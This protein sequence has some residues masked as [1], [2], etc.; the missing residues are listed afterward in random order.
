MIR[1]GHAGW[2]AGAAEATLGN[3]RRT[4]DGG[5][6]ARLTR[7]H[8]RSI[9][10]SLFEGDP[11]A[12]YPRVAVPVLLAPARAEGDPAVADALASLPDARVSYYPGA[13]HDLHA[14]HPDRLA[15]DLL[16]LIS[17]VT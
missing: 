1:A 8:H 15:A 2:P 17:A 9:V 7:D 3:L 16:R 5:V 6:R 13:H 14:Q 10:R 4:P 12:W 11:H